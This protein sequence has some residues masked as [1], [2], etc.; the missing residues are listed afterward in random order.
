VWIVT[1]FYAALF[2][3]F[4][5]L[6][7]RGTRRVEARSPHGIV[8]RLRAHP[9][10][11][12]DFEAAHGLTWDPSK[13]IGPRNWINGSG[14]ARYWLEDDLVHLQ[15][16]PHGGRE[17]L[18]VGP[19]P[20]LAEVSPGAARQARKILIMLLVLYGATLGVWWLLTHLHH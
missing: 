5:V 1:V 13:P 20:K 3:Y 16:T 12:I 15:W 6:F 17:R 11:E 2:G 18:L 4:L 14:H 9:G 7:W 10:S 19:V 8:Q